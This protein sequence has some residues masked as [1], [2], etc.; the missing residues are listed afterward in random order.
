MAGVSVLLM[1]RVFHSLI[2]MVFSAMATVA[3]A[4]VSAQ[5]WHEGSVGHFVRLAP[6]GQ[7]PLNVYV[8]EMGRGPPILFLHG[9]GGSSYSWRFVAPRMAA[10]NRVIGLDLRGFGRSDKPFDRAYSSTD[11][12][13]VV[14]AFIRQANLKR[15]TLVGHSFGGIVALRLALDRRL[16]PHRIAR[17]V[18]MDAPAFPQP[19]SAGVAFLRRP[20]LPYL[21]L[22]LVPPEVTATVALMMESVGFERF[23][24]KDISIYA[25]PLSAPGGPHALVETALQIVP[26]DL[27]QVIARYP[28][29][30]KPVLALWCRH[31]RV[32]PLTTGLRLQ[33]T[34]PGAKLAIMDGCDHMPAEQAPGA[35]VTEIRRFLGR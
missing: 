19:F 17:L 35:V 25:D 30:N 20:V 27:D 15:I 9:L 28:T 4:P 34:I 21:A 10:T 11:H 24:D 32:V 8:E 3:V 7:P 12:A 14:K 22:M 13:N 33:R 6:E 31:D 1:W 29:I 2:A 5:P 23:S 26:E 18:V 16:E